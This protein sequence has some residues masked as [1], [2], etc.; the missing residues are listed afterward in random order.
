[1]NFQDLKNV[2]HI[3]FYF[4]VAAKRTTKKIDELRQG[5]LRGSNLQRSRFL[6]L[7]K[8]ESMEKEL[9][10]QLMNILKSF[11]SFD[12]LSEFYK[13][14]IDVTLGIV[15][16]KKALAALKWCTDKN[17]EFLILYKRKIKDSTEITRIN[18]Y[19]REFYGRVGSTLKQ[20]KKSM[21]FLE[22]S[23]RTMLDF[24]T[25]KTS[26]TSI[27]IAGFPNVG[28]STLLNK[29][30][31]SKAKVGAYAFTTTGVNL[32]YTV[33]NEEKV[34]FLDVPGTLERFEKQNVIEKIAT[35]SL[36]YVAE[37]IIYVFDLTETYPLEK[38]I[39]LYESLKKTRKPIIVY[40]AKT[41][42]VDNA[43]FRKKYNAVTNVDDLKKALEKIKVI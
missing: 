9:S 3:N 13:E 16:L 22:Y 17:R 42:I 15:E 38:Q 43:E 29:L 1:M 28:K 32:G 21:E 39:K 40:L 10:E 2:E 41:D 34:Q 8:L 19:R 4:G 6:E 37:A 30:T 23:R 5:S 24:P 18:S 33:I 11:P 26:I 25:I 12:N 36:K 27:A 7:S 35:L 20:I 31:G 14:L